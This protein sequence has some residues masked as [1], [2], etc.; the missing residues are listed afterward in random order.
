MV[1]S[2]TNTFFI[3]SLFTTLCCQNISAAVK[4][5][6]GSIKNNVT[7]GA[8]A[9]GEQ[10]RLQT[11]DG[12]SENIVVEYSGVSVDYSFVR[13]TNYLGTNVGLQGLFLQ[14]QAQSEGQTILYKDKVGPI[15]PLILGAGLTAFPTEQV[16]IQFGLAAIYYQ[17]KLT[18]PTSVITSYEFIYSKPVQILAQLKFGW[19]LGE[20][21]FFQ[22][23]LFATE[24]TNGSLGWTVSLG[25][26][27]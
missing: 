5:S 9:W 15:V 12:R 3:I 16:W 10:I 2:I 7:V 4:K 8:T 22:Q 13:R 11:S 20:K 25:Y 18:A 17:L 26:T 14:G 6:A 19:Q 21:L 23:S 1:N 24:T 27:F